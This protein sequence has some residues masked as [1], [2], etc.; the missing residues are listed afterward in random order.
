MKELVE[1]PVQA[2][3]SVAPLLRDLSAWLKLALAVESLVRA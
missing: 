2:E 3:R 1:S